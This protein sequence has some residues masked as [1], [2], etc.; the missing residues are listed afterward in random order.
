I[1]LRGEQVFGTRAAEIAAPL[2]VHF[3]QG[4]DATRAVRYLDLL[5][6]IDARRCAHADAAAA[7]TRA[8]ALVDA[9]PQD[10]RPRR[11]IELL[12]A[13]G[14]SHRSAGEMSDAAG[15][16]DEAARR[17][18]VIGDRGLEVRAQLLVASACSWIDFAR[19]SAAVAAARARLPQLADDA[20]RELARGLLA[21][22]DLLIDGAADGIEASRT[23]WTRARASGDAGLEGEHAV[24]HA[25]LL[26]AAR[27]RAL[28][29]RRQRLRSDGRRV[30][31][32]ARAVA[33]GAARTL[34]CGRRGGA[35]PRRAE[36][37]SHLRAALLAPVAL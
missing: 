8:L 1:G 9:L 18:A 27:S 37:P 32:G 12:L 20:T 17:A 26:F 11:A 22:W 2:A 29:G 30:R 13:R 15:D 33:I 24:R 4:R 5:A 16:Y 14:S 19:C 34:R 6:R 31:G 25:F 7:L 28:S 21:Y 35:P 3:E 10:D 23:A 36:R